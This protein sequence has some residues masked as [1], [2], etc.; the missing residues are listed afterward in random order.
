[1]NSI[2]FYTLCYG[3]L[4]YLW[5]T[6]IGLQMVDGLKTSKYLNETAKKNINGQISLYDAE[7]IIKQYYEQSSDNLVQTEE[8]DLASIN[9]LKILADDSFNFSIPQF[10]NIHK[11][12]FDG[13]F[14]H[15]GKIRDYNISKKEWVLN[16]KTVLYGDASIIRETLEYDFSLEKNYDYC[17]IT[18]TDFV[19]HIARF[20]AN[21]W[22]IRPFS[23]GNTRTTAVFLIKYLRKFGYDV[24]NDIFAN[25]AW[26]FRNSLVRAN[27]TNFKEG[28]Y[29]TT[30]F[31]ELF[32]RNLLF[33]EKNELKNRFLHINWHQKVD[34]EDEKVDI[35]TLNLQDK[36]KDNIKIIYESLKNNDYFG[37]KEIINVINYSESGT[38]K[39]ITKLLNLKIIVPVK[40]HGKGKYKFNIK[41]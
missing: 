16:G 1:M 13:I 41:V 6:S 12:I 24:T 38:S 25:N 3:N 19:K 35:E 27:Y 32:L 21:L 4:E 30:L 40:N 37:R 7:R 11:K 39:F 22:Q 23:E 20:I 33:N 5:Y 28:I 2:V 9:I 26:Y 14:P 29:E 17:N 8:A 36:F 15:A 31:L 10:L 34:I 18:E